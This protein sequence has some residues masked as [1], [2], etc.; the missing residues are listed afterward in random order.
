MLSTKAFWRGTRNW[1]LRI[2]PIGSIFSR[3]GKTESFDDFVTLQQAQSG[4]GQN[5][6]V[7]VELYNKKK[8]ELW[9]DEKRRMSYGFPPKLTWYDT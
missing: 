2:S 7:W 8:M 3:L 1:R 4:R 5:V 6:A 9:H